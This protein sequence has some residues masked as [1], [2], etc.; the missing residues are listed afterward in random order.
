VRSEQ[1]AGAWDEAAPLIARAVERQG[2]YDLSDV[3]ALCETADAQLW[4]AVDGGVAVGAVV[5]KVYDFPCSRV[6]QIWLCGGDSFDKWGAA[7]LRVIEEWASEIGAKRVR[8]AGRKGWG[9]VLGDYEQT[10]VVLE[11]CL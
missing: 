11:K 6:V 10:S 3:R 8:I 7:I 1:V 9:R 2:D 4:M 5:T